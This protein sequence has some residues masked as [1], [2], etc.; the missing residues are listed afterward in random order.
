[1]GKAEITIHGAGAFGLA[2]AYE[3]AKRG[4]RVRL[5]DPNGIGAGSSGG[6]VGALAP[7]T[8]ER[9][10]EK[11]EF[12]FRSLLLSRD[13]WPEVEAMG[14]VSSG[15]GRTGRVQA[16]ADARQL[17][18]AREREAQ[19]KEF[20]RGAA[21]WR[22]VTQGETGYWAPQSPTGFLVHDTLSAR[23][24]PW[25]ACQ[26]LAAAITALGGEIATEGAEEGAVIHATG[27]RGLAALGAA[28][29]REVGNGVKGQAI[30]LD[31][32]LPEAPQ[33][34]GEGLH[35]IP[36]ADGTTAIGSTSEREF[37]APDT[38]DAQAD[39]LLA[40]ALAVVPMLAQARE[41]R[42]W[43][44]VRP[45]A[46]SRAPMLGPWPGRP[47][48]FVANGGFKIG[49]GMAPLAA[50]VLVELVLEGRDAIPAAFRV[51][52]SL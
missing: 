38:T 20:W 35:V 30:L 9:W 52:A 29:G 43:A 31:L 33:I 48:H 5:L 18:L 37:D 24:N 10:N 28:L 26:A 44:G 8:P 46:R 14:G 42:R 7:H 50:Q 1:M 12:Q 17:G 19:A 45:R 2:C 23:L 49:Y 16:I 3:A 39:A 4:A 6:V 47:G 22:V 15:Y 27:W 21:D 32:A 36:H 51:E 25:R 41:I 11:K 13:F 40:R 34:Y